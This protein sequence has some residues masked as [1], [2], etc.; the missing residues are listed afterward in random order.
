MSEVNLEHLITPWLHNFFSL[1]F[2]LFCCTFILFVECKKLSS[3]LKERMKK[4]P[5]RKEINYWIEWVSEWESE[6]SSVIP[7]NLLKFYLP[8]GK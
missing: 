2:S 7:E 8:K 3:E 5:Q 4:K 1:S 6:L